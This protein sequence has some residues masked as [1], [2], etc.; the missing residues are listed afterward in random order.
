ESPGRNL[1]IVDDLAIVLADIYSDGPK[2]RIDV[3]DLSPDR[4]SPRLLEN[5]YFEG[6]LSA[7][8][9]INNKLHL[10]TYFDKRV[11]GLIYYPS[12]EDDYYDKSPE[13]QDI[14]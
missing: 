3:I 5:Y 1:L 10:A 8:R 11:S 4:K 9:K 13:E 14:L 12:V 6:N 2:L 7:A